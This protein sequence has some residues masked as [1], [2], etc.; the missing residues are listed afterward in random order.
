MWCPPAWPAE[1]MTL[2]TVSEPLDTVAW[3][4][5]KQTFNFTERSGLGRF[6]DS[7]F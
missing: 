2:P 3:R 4:S 7:P 6:D 5:T 1:N